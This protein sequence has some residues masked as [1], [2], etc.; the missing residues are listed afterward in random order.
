M[1]EGEDV[2]YGRPLNILY[3][4]VVPHYLRFCYLCLQQ[5]VYKLDIRGSFLG[6]P[7]ILLIL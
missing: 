3:S 5:I 7:Q 6:C 1:K 4:A 2:I